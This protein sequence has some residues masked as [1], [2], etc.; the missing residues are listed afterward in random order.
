M[1]KQKIN[2]IQIILVIVSILVVAV[3]G[4]IFVNLGMDWF[5]SLIRPSQWIPNIIIPIVWTVIYITFGI[6]LESIRCD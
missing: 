1:E 4:S 3:L 6:I 2:I 5:N